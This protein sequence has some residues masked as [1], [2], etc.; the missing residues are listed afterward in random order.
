MISMLRKYVTAKYFLSSP[1]HPQANRK[2]L[3]IPHPAPCR[4]I[5][6]V[7]LCHHPRIPFI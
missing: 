5:T 7:S 1:L 2:V 6:S 4:R 3:P